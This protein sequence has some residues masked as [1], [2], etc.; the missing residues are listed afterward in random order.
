MEQGAEVNWLDF[1]TYRRVTQRQWNSY[2]FPTAP[3]AAMR[4]KAWDWT[5]KIARIWI[6]GRSW[7]LALYPPSRLQRYGAQINRQC[8]RMLQ[9]RRRLRCA[10]LPL[11][12][13]ARP[14]VSCH[15]WNGACWTEDSILSFPCG[16]FA[17]VRKVSKLAGDSLWVQGT[18]LHGAPADGRRG[19][20]L[21]DLTTRRSELKCMICLWCFW[22]EWTRQSAR[23][24]R[25]KELNAEYL[26]RCLWICILMFISPESGPLGHDPL[27]TV[28]KTGN[29]I[30]G[31]NADRGF[32]NESNFYF[33]CPDPYI[34]QNLKYHQ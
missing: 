10:L 4:E 7:F 25:Q 26:G 14:P 19:A 30:K 16:K 34:Q 8:I 20:A 29:L 12:G 23:Q 1:T 6:A 5:W 31:R 15:A 27:Q 13:F 32:F 9:L 22:C 33:L 11:R 24:H 2:T 3:S 17:M 21:N 18:A 28:I